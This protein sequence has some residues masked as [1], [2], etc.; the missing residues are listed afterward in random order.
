MSSATVSLVQDFGNFT[1]F[2]FIELAKLD[3]GKVSG[4]DILQVLII[5]I[6]FFL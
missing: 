4:G 1:S 3:A 2:K 5:I 6:A